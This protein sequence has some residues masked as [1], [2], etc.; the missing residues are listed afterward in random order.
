MEIEKSASWPEIKRGRPIIYPFEKLLPASKM[1]I[2][3]TG[4]LTKLRVSVF[5]SLAYYKQKNG[6]I[7]DSR[8]LIEGENIAVY[9]K[10]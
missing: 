1:T 3:G 6:L 2:Q 8:V 7:W 10:N 4:D 9:R 5:N